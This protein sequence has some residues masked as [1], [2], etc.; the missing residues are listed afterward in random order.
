MK[1]GVEA[2]DEG[3]WGREDEVGKWGWERFSFQILAVTFVGE[4]CVFYSFPC[5][6]KGRR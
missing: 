3:G 5:V 6:K 2:E 4:N 1:E